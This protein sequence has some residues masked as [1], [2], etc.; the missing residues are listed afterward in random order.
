MQITCVLR[1]VISRDKDFVFT[2]YPINKPLY[3][4][5]FTEK[6]FSVRSPVITTRSG[7]SMFILSSIESAISGT[8]YV[9][10]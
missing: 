4:V 5:I 6:P 8:K 1:I 10:E 2:C 7:L 3:S 9:S